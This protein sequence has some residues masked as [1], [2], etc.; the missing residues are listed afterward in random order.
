MLFS[1]W[2]FVLIEFSFYGSPY[3]VDPQ[4]PGGFVN[5]NHLLPYGQRFSDDAVGS[6]IAA[7][8]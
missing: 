6:R 8:S 7:N 5:D 2:R 4:I 1:W 3:Q